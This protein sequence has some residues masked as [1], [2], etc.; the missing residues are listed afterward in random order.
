MLVS[1]GEGK[2]VS[3]VPA[4]I[5]GGVMDICQRGVAVSPCYSRSVLY[6]RAV[7]FIGTFTCR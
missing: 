2:E 6:L 1:N 5:T 3:R 4:C 7:S